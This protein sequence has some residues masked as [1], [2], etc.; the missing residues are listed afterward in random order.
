MDIAHII[1]VI[2]DKRNLWF[3]VYVVCLDKVINESS[4]I[5]IIQ[6]TICYL[7]DGISKFFQSYEYKMYFFV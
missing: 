3:I 4:L 7:F 5:F 1:E 6:V 2:R